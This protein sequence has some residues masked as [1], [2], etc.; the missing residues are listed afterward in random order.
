MA[1]IWSYSLSPA[2]F[3]NGPTLHTYDVLPVSPSGTF[4]TTKSKVLFGP[5]R[6][7]TSVRSLGSVGVL[8]SVDD[9]L[10]NPPAP[11]VIERRRK[12]CDVSN[13]FA[14]H[15]NKVLPTILRYSAFCNSLLE[16]RVTASRLACIISALL[17]LPL[18]TF[19]NFSRSAAAACSTCCSCMLRSHLARIKF[20]SGSLRVSIAS[21]T[22]FDASSLDTLPSA[23]ACMVALKSLL[24]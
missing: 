6:R 19:S 12:D 9:A 13:G 11:G 14:P 17:P 8:E 4:C 5:L 21:H 22:L 18:W 10:S 24:T 23:R 3:A 7:S 16:R 2:S 15:D 1:T 20:A